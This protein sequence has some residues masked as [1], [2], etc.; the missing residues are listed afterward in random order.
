MNVCSKPWQRLVSL[1]LSTVLLTA[2]AT[3]H[4]APELT[5]PLPSWN[6]GS[7]RDAIISFVDAV[8]NPASP[9]F[10]PVAGR[11]AVF[12][13]DGTL[14]SEQPAYF[15]FFFALDQVREMAAQHP[16]WANEQPFKAVLEND[17]P[18]LLAQGEAGLI[19]VM[20]AAHAG[21]TTEAFSQSVADWLNTARHPRFDQPYTQLIYQPMLEVLDYLR[22]NDFQTWIVSGGG[23]DF[24]RVFSEQAYGIPPQQVVGS[25][26][27]TRFEMR[28]SGPVLM[29]EPTI[30]FVDDKEGKPVGI[31][32]HI[33]KRPIAA[34]GNSD[35]DLQMLQWTAAGEGPSLQVFIHHTDAEREWAYDREGHIGRLDAGL[36]EAFAYD[37][38]VVDMQQD[39]KLI[40]PF[41]MQP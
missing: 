9:D 22:A 19:P 12:D 14:W 1:V 8:T 35:G 33:G 28:D 16:E 4:A 25:S 18:A 2:C 40:Y 30:S 32:Q 38:L 17:M 37:W 39:W 20:M 13:N 24:I 34:F 26:V 36:D 15:Q 27:V 6:A 29:R 23:I 5:D 21:M 41:Q 11:I 31:H 10:V 7:S 3:Q